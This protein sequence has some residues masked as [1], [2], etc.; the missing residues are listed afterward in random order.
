MRQI[1]ILSILKSGSL[2]AS[3][4]LGTTL[5]NPSGNWSSVFRG[6][7]LRERT[8]PYSELPV[9]SDNSPPAVPSGFQL[10]K[11]TT[12]EVS[13]TDGLDGTYT[14]YSKANSSSPEPVIA[15]N[16]TRVRVKQTISEDRGAGGVVTNCSTY[17]LLK[18]GNPVI[19]NAGT[20][21][22]VGGLQLFG[23]GSTTWGESLQQNMVSLASNFAS[24]IP[25]LNPLVGQHW[26]DSLH[27]KTRVWTGDGWVCISGSDIVSKYEH[28]QSS[29]SSTWVIQHNLNL[30]SPYLAQA[31]F[32]AHASGVTTSINPTEV[33]LSTNQIIAT[34]EEQ[35]AGY[36]I[37]KI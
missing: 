34:F 29:P 18:F 2:P 25:P 27:H 15:G 30:P 10:V 36:A 12:F 22:D 5:D 3:F 8:A 32:F 24:D 4:E 14:V 7:Y 6:T 16:T 35:V 31:F 11:A 37:I 28:A 9:Y 1:P 21:I 26:Y 17:Y 19:V 33:L 13:G 20:T 23:R